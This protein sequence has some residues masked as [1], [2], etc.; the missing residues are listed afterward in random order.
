MHPF[1]IQ[2]TRG[3]NLAW[4]L[5]W[6]FDNLDNFQ[7]KEFLVVCINQSA[8]FLVVIKTAKNGA[9]NVLSGKGQFS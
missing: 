7:F 4:W 9:K 8:S 2:C 1:L 5:D 3:N 6:K